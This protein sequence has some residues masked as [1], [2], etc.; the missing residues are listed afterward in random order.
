VV[1]FEQ[2]FVARYMMIALMAL[3]PRDEDEERKAILS[4]FN[5]NPNLETYIYENLDREPRFYVCEKRF[6]DEWAEGVSFNKSDNQLGLK[7]L[8]KIT[9]R[10]ARLLE[11]GHQYR[12]GDV[13]Y[14]EDYVLLPKHAFL[15]LAAWYGCDKSITRDVISWKDVVGGPRKLTRKSSILQPQKSSTFSMSSQKFFNPSSQAFEAD[16]QKRV[17]DTVYEVDIAPKVL[18]LSQITDK[19]EK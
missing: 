15:P 1:D 16:L 11:P 6:W 4:V 18:Y 5:F 14:N 3:T 10:N 17:A 12:M 9:M 8:S 2:I 19:G 7:T 13:A